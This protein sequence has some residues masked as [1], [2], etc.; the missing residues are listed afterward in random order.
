LEALANHLGKSTVNDDDVRRFLNTA[1][2]DA[3]E[4]AMV[5]YQAV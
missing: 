3:L 4:D 1:L 2:H 5:E